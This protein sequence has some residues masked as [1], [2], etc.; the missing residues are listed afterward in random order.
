M[1]YS[2]NKRVSWIEA[3]N[4]IY[5]GAAQ[6]KGILYT[7]FQLSIS[8]AT[9]LDSKKNFIAQTSLSVLYIKF[10]NFISFRK[11]KPIDR[12]DRKPDLG[13]SSLSSSKVR[14]KLNAYRALTR[15]YETIAKS[16]M[17]VGEQKIICTGTK[18]SYK[19]VIDDKSGI[20]ILN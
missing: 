18:S 20:R 8:C 2:D 16:D 12:K 1:I 3:S 13:K 6:T 19:C 11:K 4:L 10:I 14:V 17:E 15:K 7:A 9:I 5:L